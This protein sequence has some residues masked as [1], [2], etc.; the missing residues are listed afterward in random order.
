MLKVS[1]GIGR[2][3]TEEKVSLGLTVLLSMVTSEGI[4]LAILVR[5][6]ATRVCI[7]SDLSLRFLCLFFI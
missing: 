4:G 7:S 1:A 3:L 5:L 6:E 2:M